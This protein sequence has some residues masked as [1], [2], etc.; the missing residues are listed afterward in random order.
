MKQKILH[1]DM[2]AF[3]ARV[4]KVDRPELRGK[5]V[6]VGGQSER[7]VV[8]TACY[9]ARQHGVHSAMPMAQARKLCP[10]ATFLPVRGERYKEISRTIQKIMRS[11]T[12]LV[13]P[14]SLDEAYLDVT[15]V[16]HSDNSAYEI[17]R[18]IKQEIKKQT[19]LTCSIGIGPNKMIA[20]LASEDCK[21]DGLQEIKEEEKDNF[22]IH[23]P[24]DAIP[25]IGEKTGRELERIGINSIKELRE[26]ESNFLYRELGT[27]GIILQKRGLGEDSTPVKANEETK[28]ISNEETYP[29]DLE[30]R[31]IIKKFLFRLME[32]VGR[33]LR[34]KKLEAKTVEVKVRRGDFTTLTRSYTGRR[35]TDVTERLWAAVV[36]LFEEIKIDARGVRLLGVGV[37]N[38]RPAASQ[39]E[40]FEASDE[41][42]KARLNELMDNLNEEY[43]DQTIVRGGTII[44]QD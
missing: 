4:E 17:A 21:P 18:Q 6:V 26:A 36:A 43:G 10:E 20:K 1:I 23:L 38:L 3:F 34:D 16:L 40:L 37:S 24:L 11:Y 7:G 13:E 9:R 14:V 35:H 27:R 22:M 31:K 32:K 33:R 15:G 44:G 41:Q 30:D 28:S 42:R 5:A 19:R 29:E 2:D 25:G 8:S 39:E 12:P